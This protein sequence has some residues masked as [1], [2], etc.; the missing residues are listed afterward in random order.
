MSH[1]LSVELI[2]PRVPHHIIYK[3][4]L[5]SLCVSID[6]NVSPGLLLPDSGKHA[7]LSLVC[8]GTTRIRNSRNSTATK[9]AG[10]IAPQGNTVL[11]TNGQPIQLDGG[12]EIQWGS[13]H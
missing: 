11:D 7:I 1:Q 3:H 4:A 5:N 6:D 12:A 9:V 13:K 10:D 8:P 2:I